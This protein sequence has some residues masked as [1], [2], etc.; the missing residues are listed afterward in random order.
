M[1]RTLL[2][3]ASILTGLLLWQ[4]EPKDDPIDDPDAPVISLIT[5]MIST[6]PGH[7]F[8][9]EAS[10]TDDVGLKSVNLLK[11]DWFLDKDITLSDSIRK[12][13]Q[14][15]YRFLTPADSEEN[16]HSLLITVEDL[17]GNITSKEVPISLDK[18]IEP[19]VFK[20]SSPQDGSNLFAGEKLKMFIEATDNSGIDSFAISAPELEIDTLVVFDPVNPRYI[21]VKDYI[22]PD[23]IPDGNYFISVV[24]S[25]STANKRVEI[26]SIIVGKP[27]VGEVYCVGGATWSGWDTPDNPMLMRH[28][29]ENEGWYELICHSFGEQDQNGVKFVGQ[30]AWGPLNWGLDP[31]NPSQMIM[32]EGSLKIILEEEGYHKVR[33]SPGEMAYSTEFVGAETPVRSEMYLLGS[34]I[35]GMDNAYLD[36]SGALPMTQDPE[37]PYIYTA[38]VE[39]T[40]IGV[41]DWGASFIFIGNKDDVSEFNLGFWYYPGDVLDPDWLDYYG[42]VKGDLSLNLDPLTTEQLPNISDFPPS[43]GNWNGVPYIAYYMQ[44]G[45]YLIKLDYHIG[46]ASVTKVS[47]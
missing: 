5:T 46:H 24:A 32:D 20:I 1:K 23:P 47:K 6:A 21:F 9:I 2:F 10:I 39:F 22:I 3:Y 11:Q 42:Y 27:S 31:D 4:C 45:T 8:W 26:I 40:D 38:I 37:N 43:N 19:P 33:F 7:E 16:D 25:D 17:G 12:E 34:G 13:Y 29:D 30:R 14:L 41:D 28:D 44:A 36:P 15:L 35:V 18:D